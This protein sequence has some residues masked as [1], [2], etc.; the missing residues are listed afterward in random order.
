VFEGPIN[1]R[2]SNA[3]LGT[4][5]YIATSHADGSS[6]DWAVVSYPT[7]RKNVDDTGSRRFQGAGEHAKSVPEEAAP[8]PARALE[9]IEFPVEVSALIAERLWTG[10]SLIIT[11]ESLS[12]ET[13]DVGTDLVVTMR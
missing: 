13:S 12:D 5:V 3:P 11:D 1:I 2:D 6:L 7:S 10:G 8:D 4:H 9:R